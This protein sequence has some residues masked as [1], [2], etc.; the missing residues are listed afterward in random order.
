MAI[1]VV[2]FE[3]SKSVFQSSSQP[4]SA[5]GHLPLPQ[6]RRRVRLVY[7]EFLASPPG[8]SPSTPN[9]AI[10]LPANSEGPI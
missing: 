10:Y 2:G 1:S 5:T 3:L 8:Y 4:N 6:H 9:R 7:L